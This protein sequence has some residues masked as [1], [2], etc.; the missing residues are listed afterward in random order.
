MAPVLSCHEVVKAYRRQTVL[1][2]VSLTVEAGRVVGLLGL[3][4]AG[5]TTLMR[6][7]TGLLAPDAGEVR[8]LGEPLP[9][10]PAVLNRVGAALDAPAFH[11]WMTGRGALRCLLDIAGLPDAGRIDRLLERVGLAEAAGRRIKG[12]SQGMRQRL[13]LAAALLK[14]PDLLILDEP[15]N[16]LDPQGVRL[17]RAIVQEEAARGA[18]V[19]VSSHL[20]D[21]IARMCDELIMVSRGVVTARGT[22][23][24]LGF[25]AGGD[26]EEWFF[27][28]Q[29]GAEHAS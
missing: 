14:E 25:D 23:A 5:K 1:D 6:I 21:E 26:L 17:V 29:R 22:L 2:G 24:D 27:A 3:N 19:L 13:A 10:R 12:Y 18:A 8:I 4:G 16:G 28:Q 15:T 9:M 20:L 7:A 11:P